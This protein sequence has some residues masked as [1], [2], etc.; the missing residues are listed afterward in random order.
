M[1]ANS[2][3][4][5]WQKA[6][7]YQIYPRSFADGNGDGI[8]DFSGMTSKLE[9]LQELGIDAIWLSPHYPSPFVDCGYDVSDYQDVGA[10]YGRLE[11]FKQFLAQVHQR[12]MHLVLDMV[13]NHTSDQHPWFIE[14]RSSRDNAKRDWYVWKDGEAGNPPNNWFSAFGGS[15]WEYD[16]RTSSYYYHYFFKEQPDLN[17]HNPAVKKAMFDAVRFW[18]D[19]GVDGFRLDAVGTIFEDEEYPSI[20]SGLSQEELYRMA[21]KT[22]NLDADENVRAYFFEMFQH[23]TDKPE[24]HE[25]MKELRVVINEYEDRVL[26]GETDAIEFYGDGT[27]EL[28]LNF[29]FPLLQTNRLTA[30][31]VKQNQRQ[32]LSALPEQAWPCNTL[33]NHDVSRMLTAFGDGKNN[34]IQAKLHLMM[35]LTLKGTPF[36][37]NGEEIGMSDFILEDP[38]LFRDPLS[39]L[40]ARLEKEVNGSDEKTVVRVGAMMGRD[41][42]RTPMQWSDSPNAGFC[43]QEITP[44]LPVNPNYASGINVQEQVSQPDSMINFYRR[45]LLTRRQHPA[46]QV[47]D[48]EELDTGNEEVFCYRRKSNEDELL[49]VLNMSADRQKVILPR[50]VKQILLNNMRNWV[51][52]VDPTPTLLPYQGIIYRVA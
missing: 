24:V 26:I 16:A 8:G 13:L 43:P 17:W 29:N 23:Q 6:V 40:Y 7:F 1:Q 2:E 10:E 12:G 45:M 33:G 39:L 34:E 38:A 46:L 44:W 32:R 42:N 4:K 22:A 31:H 18:L 48:Y 19:L 52:I 49:V 30:Q 21:S 47:G 20:Q 37:Y 9:Y 15:A 11:D 41:R 50:T 36:L 27:N 28:H 51:Q 14:S 25:L 35:L 3:Y 5:W